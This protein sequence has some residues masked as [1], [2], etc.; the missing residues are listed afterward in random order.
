MRG[1]RRLDN[2][3]KGFLIYFDSYP[4]VL[5]LP[6]EERGRLFT[7]LISYADQAWRE[8]ARSPEEFLEGL[9]SLSDQGAMAF[10]FMAAYILRDTQ[11]WLSRRKGSRG[12]GRDQAGRAGRAPGRE[13]PREEADEERKREMQRLREDTELT[14]KV[15]EKF[16]LLQ[17]EGPGEKEGEAP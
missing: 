1:E 16:H 9:P 4:M 14:R 15:L 8:D 6:P 3:K 11:L 10:S 12:A 2:A 5:R 7:A 13:G 17:G